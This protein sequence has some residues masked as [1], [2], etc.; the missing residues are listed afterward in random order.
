[1]EIGIH[2]LPISFYRLDIVIASS[3]DYLHVENVTPDFE[4]SLKSDL[5]REYCMSPKL[6][7]GNYTQYV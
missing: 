5:H 1:M 2:G 7:R 3:E 4:Q 6:V